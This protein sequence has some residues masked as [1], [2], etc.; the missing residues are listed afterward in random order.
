MPISSKT[1]I[2]TGACGALALALALAGLP[3]SG[4]PARAD[5]DYVRP[6]TDPLVKKECG[7]CHLAFPAGFLPAASWKAIMAGLEDHFGDDASLDA[8]DAKKI[9]AY[10]VAHAADAGRRWRKRRGGEGKPPLRITKLGWFVS[11]HRGEVSARARKRA[12]TMANCAACHRGA[13]R[14]Y[15][16]DD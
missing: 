16:D 8:E 10:L 6:V 13:E 11:E 15:F 1:T 4:G 9:E 7:A 5:D 14:G 3:G 12:G 2:M